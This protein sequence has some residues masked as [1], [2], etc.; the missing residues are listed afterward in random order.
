LGEGG[1]GKK[2]VSGP[3]GKKAKKG[4]PTPRPGRPVLAHRGRRGERRGGTKEKDQRSLHREG[5][6]REK[7][8]ENKGSGVPSLVE[9]GGEP[10]RRGKDTSAPASYYC[11]RPPPTVI[12][13]KKKGG[14]EKGSPSFQ[15]GKVNFS[16][17]RYENGLKKKHLHLK[18]P[19]LKAELKK[20]KR[21]RNGYGGVLKKGGGRMSCG[22]EN[23]QSYYG[24]KKKKKAER[25][26]VATPEK[27]TSTAC[28]DKKRERG[29]IPIEVENVAKS[30]PQH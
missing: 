11:K 20:V 4:L 29:Q 9:R 2:S 14:K 7:K 8:K 27:G 21:R 18:R 6:K 12:I 10:G 30:L 28:G 15:L 24:E 17:H 5:A 3:S 25:R 22:R 13:C 16:F 1:G 23:L 19:A 26:T